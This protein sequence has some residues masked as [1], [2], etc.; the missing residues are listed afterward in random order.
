MNNQKLVVVGTLAVMLSA[1]MYPPWGWSRNPSSGRDFGFL[2]SG[3]SNPQ[4]SGLEYSI[5]WQI[6]VAEL[7]AIAL[8][9]AI[10]YVLSKK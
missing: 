7:V 5:N 10:I 6:L 3:P 8:V 2:F 4:Y 9:G 1:I